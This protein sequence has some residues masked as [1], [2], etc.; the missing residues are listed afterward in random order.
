MGSKQCD[1]FLSSLGSG[2]IHRQ[3]PCTILPIEFSS[4]F[5]TSSL[6]G[7]IYMCREEATLEENI[8]MCVW[9]T[10][11]AVLLLSALYSCFEKT[12]SRSPFPPIFGQRCFHPQD[13]ASPPSAGTAGGSPSQ[14]HEAPQLLTTTPGTCGIQLLLLLKAEGLRE[15]DGF[16]PAEK[17]PFT[18]LF[19]FGRKKQI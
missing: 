1:R 16:R 6:R 8:K 2:D 12:S 13:T 3:S 15:I 17:N 19:N 10:T 4:R 5:P 18:F 11:T 14:P 7:N 9:H